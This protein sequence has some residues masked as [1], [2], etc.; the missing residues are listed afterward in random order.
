MI[1]VSLGGA[2]SSR[3]M[4]IVVD[5]ERFGFVS[6]LSSAMRIVFERVVRAILGSFDLHAQE[7]C[8]QN[9]PLPRSLKDYVIT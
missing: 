7:C 1:L 6:L 5:D 9:A 3:V 4:V 2:R 8:Y